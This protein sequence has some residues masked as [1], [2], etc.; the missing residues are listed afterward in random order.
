MNNQLI[1]Y[2]NMHKKAL[3]LFLTIL[4]LPG[5]SY[6]QSLTEKLGGATTNF[7]FLINKDTIPVVDQII[8]RRGC[9]DCTLVDGSEIYNFEFISLYEVLKPELSYDMELIDADG[10]ILF[11]MRINQNNI[12]SYLNGDNLKIYSI[13]L[14]GIPLIVFNRTHSIIFNQ[15]QRPRILRGGRL[16]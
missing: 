6:S 15:R 1:N 14:Q 2:L 9:S 7:N 5:Y 11:S 16:R 13:S 8:I 10:L 3:L 12:L 4:L